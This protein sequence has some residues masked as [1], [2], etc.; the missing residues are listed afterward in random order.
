LSNFIIIAVKP[1]EVI[2]VKVIM[3]SLI[4]V[5]HFDARWD[6]WSVRKFALRFYGVVLEVAL[7]LQQLTQDERWQDNTYKDK[8]A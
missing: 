5:H 7:D 3:Y 8:V 4:L 2:H 1:R 6:M